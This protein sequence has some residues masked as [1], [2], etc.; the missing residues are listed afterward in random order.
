MCL[1]NH[2]RGTVLSKA[3]KKEKC[4]LSV[5]FY[6]TFEMRFV[7]VHTVQCNLKYTEVLSGMNWEPLQG[8]I[9]WLSFPDVGSFLY[10]RKW[11]SWE[12]STY[13]G[14]KRLSNFALK[15]VQLWPLNFWIWEIHIV[16]RLN[17]CF[18]TLWYQSKL[19]CTVHCIL[20]MFNWI[21]SS[22]YFQFQVMQ[23]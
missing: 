19:T 13:Q 12:I 17:F 14:N 22:S 18:C 9:F 8:S 2:K 4:F 1:P 21:N 7:E 6:I 5:V 10:C 23:K 3:I 11:K 20:E 16:T 15:F